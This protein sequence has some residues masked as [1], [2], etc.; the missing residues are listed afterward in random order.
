MERN[1]YNEEFEDLIKQ[2]ADQYKM[3]PS[4]KV[5]KNI[6]GSLHTRRR[7]FIAGMFT[8]ITGILFFAG[9]E[10]L[11]PSTHITPPK[12]AITYN[13]RSDNNNTE[14]N[15][16]DNNSSESNLSPTKK[17]A[18]TPVIIAPA[19]VEFNPDGTASE[20]EGN[21]QNEGIVGASDSIGNIAGLLEGQPNTI[22]QNVAEETYSDFANSLQLVRRPFQ[23]L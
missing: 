17:I 20:K 19:F 3:Y 4:D 16:A 6:H 2:K 18:E 14:N 9:K 21:N 22:S 5:W 23:Y 13:N 1:F 7:W 11:A 10:L 8:L 15:L 12:K